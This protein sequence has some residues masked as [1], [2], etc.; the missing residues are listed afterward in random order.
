M[1]RRT[2]GAERRAGRLSGA[3][4]WRSAEG[5][6]LRNPPARRPERLELPREASLNRFRWPKEILA[7]LGTVPD[8]VV[9]EGTGL[10]HRTVGEERRRRGI[11]P[12]IGWRPK[13]EWTPEMIALLGTM[14]DAEVAR[15]LGM[16]KTTVC[17][18]RRLRDIPPFTPP[19]H[20]SFR[21]YPWSPEDLALL[22]Q[23]SDHEVAR[24]LGLCATT[25]RLK[26]VK[27]GIPPFQ[28]RPE[29]IAWT[30]ERLARLGRCPDSQLAE[31][32]GISTA[33]V[34]RKRTQLGIPACLEK[35]PVVR[36]KRAAQLLRLPNHQV[37]ARTGLGWATIES[38]RRDLEIEP[39]PAVP[40]DVSPEGPG[41]GG[42]PPRCPEG[43]AGA[44]GIPGPGSRRACGWL[45]EE[46]ALLGTAPDAEIAALLARTVEGVARRRSQLAI[47]PWRSPPW[48]PEELALLGTAPDSEVAARLG[49]SAD[50]LGYR[51]RKAGIPAYV[52]QSW[53][54]AEIAVLGT[55]PDLEVAA[56]LGRSLSAV[57]HKRRALGIARA[58]SPQDWCPEE[59]ALLGTGPDREV[60]ARLERS[61]K[62]VE[63]KRLRLGIPPRRR[64]T[65]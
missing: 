50:H 40:P 36:S 14:T 62:A 1:S 26:R 44:G 55:L 32:F 13:F 57:Q 27:L 2:K 64:R 49:C 12:S 6:P 25:V 34:L 5:A 52:D 21:R 4:E 51:R 60:A 9:A 31:E 17:T 42:K 16:S 22:G 19:A 63:L 43:G 20:D 56:R 8:R 61:A 7:L 30:P 33:A 54:A 45:P 10:H 46:V 41:A 38:L 58:P 39:P 29:P 59:I 35:R 18:E 48:G 28:E 37:R 3:R 47:A 65:R 15:G 53:K 23:V 24:L 11:P